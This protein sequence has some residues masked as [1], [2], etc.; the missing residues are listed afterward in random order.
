MM[1]WEV[2][3]TLNNT[4]VV[5]EYETDDVNCTKTEIKTEIYHS[6]PMVDGEYIGM[7]KLDWR[8]L[9]L[10]KVVDNENR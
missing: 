6:I 4:P 5:L 9:K 7:P 3:G 1:I 10:R 2:R 8:T